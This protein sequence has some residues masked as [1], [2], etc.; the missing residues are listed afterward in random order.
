M[1]AR[2]KGPLIITHHADV[3]GRPLLKRLVLPIYHRLVGRAALRRCHFQE[4]RFM[5]K[6]LPRR[7]GPFVTIPHG[8]DEKIYQLDFPGEEVARDRIRLAGHAP[9]VGFIG[10]F[11]RYKGLSVIV[12]AL[13]QLPGVH[14]LMI[15][16]GPLRE[17]TVDG[18][19]QPELP[20]ECILWEA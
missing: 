17:Q 4:E 14:A 1:I 7:A 20:T 12:D 9:I 10:R 19:K 8:L 15:G 2:Y 18:R 16:D 3:F 5:S 6:D 11:V 13:A